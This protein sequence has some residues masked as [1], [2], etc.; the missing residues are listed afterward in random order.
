MTASIPPNAEPTDARA[1]IAGLQAEIRRLQDQI[2]ERE[3]FFFR[4]L[5]T[6]ITDGL[7]YL[8]GKR[9]MPRAAILGLVFAYLRPGIV[10]VVGSLVG[11]SVAMLQ[12][13]LLYAQNNLIVGQN[14]I[15]ER[16]SAFFEA[17]TTATRQ[18]AVS[19]LIASINTD[20]PI[21]RSLA[22]AQL[23]EYGNDT[24][25]VL[26][27]VL[28][29]PYYVMP[30][31]LKGFAMQIVLTQANGHS[32]QDV[33]ETLFNV[34]VRFAK[35]LPATGWGPAGAG[36]PMGEWHRALQY[37]LEGLALRCARDTPFRSAML[38]AIQ[39]K[40]AAWT[41]VLAQLS[42]PELTPASVR[43]FAY[44]VRSTELPGV[45]QEYFRKLD[46]LDEAARRREVR[47]WLGLALSAAN[48]NASPFPLRWGRPT[49]P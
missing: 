20:D 8:Q 23:A 24:A 10:I 36:I 43:R 7:E 9:D 11:L 30:D 44:A 19:S 3:V 32:P 6:F 40:P 2:K 21:R 18:Q 35:G 4:A 48:Q 28:G 45:N 34:S 1:D 25:P 41:F 22:M 46:S 39:A 13:Y 38:A 14:R 49:L 16:Q 17:Q 37:Y 33:F 26:N 5:R 15:L 31:A 27:R 12:L 29:D 47:G 42:A